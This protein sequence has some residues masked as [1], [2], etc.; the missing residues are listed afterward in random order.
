M[1]AALRDEIRAWVAAN[2]SDTITVRQWWKRLA[3]AGL[4][5][6][7]WP[8]PYGR[9]L[10]R[11]DAQVVTEE[12]VRVGAIAAPTGVIAVMLAGPTLLAHGTPEQQ[13]RYI[14]AIVRGDD[15]WCQLYSEPGAGSDLPNLSTSAVRDGDEWIINGQKVWNSGADLARR[16]LLLAR[17]DPT[18]PKRDGITYFLI[19]MDQP[20]IEVRPLRQMN[21]EAHFC[22]VFLTDARVANTDI[23]GGETC[24]NKGWS[25]ARTTLNLERAGATE[26][27][28]RGLRAVASGEVAGNLDR[29][30]GDVL[31]TTDEHQPTF[32]GS[33]VPA[34]HLI[35]L[36][37]ERGVTTDPVMRQQ[38][39]RYYVLTEV[40]RYNQRRAVAAMRAK[41]A[42]GAEGSIA[43]L[44]LGKICHASRDL[45]FSILGATA[46]LSG[47]DAPHHG[48]LQ[49]VGLSSPG[50]SIGGGTDEIQRNSIGERVLG[51]AREPSLD[52]EQPL[53]RR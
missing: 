8:K 25:A 23:L 28:A 39:M 17:T 22:E 36:A 5:A 52:T 24:L 1:P 3:D 9:G 38:L 31:A 37:R 27:S 7:T 35:T 20:G 2:W 41:K 13:Q 26:R 51:L 53:A 21:G 48:E 47:E 34:R 10:S 18:V 40:H 49:T 14:P 43:K 42:T 16:G 32:S 33:A 46:M 29:I 6:P 15:S 30:V 50:A 12:L 44:V 19:D 4:S 11:S 45:S